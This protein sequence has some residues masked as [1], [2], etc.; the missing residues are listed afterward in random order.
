MTGAGRSPARRSMFDRLFG[1]LD[2]SGS[3]GGAAYA[4]P[5]PG[6][7]GYSGGCLLECN[8]ITAEKDPMSFSPP[9]YVADA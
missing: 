5:Q 9:F 8:G 1:T 7:F 3:G 4:E 6:D 2:D